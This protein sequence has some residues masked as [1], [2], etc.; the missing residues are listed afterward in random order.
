[1][2]KNFRR[3]GVTFGSGGAM[4]VSE[5][6]ITTKRSVTRTP[7]STSGGSSRGGTNS[8]GFSEDQRAREAAEAQRRAA[9]EAQRKAAEE[10]ARI[11]AEEQ[12][13]RERAIQLEAQIRAGKIEGQ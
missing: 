5:S 9:E 4:S 7:S 10:S 1:M 11:A 3:G 13:A 2:V 6:P 12:R 8:R